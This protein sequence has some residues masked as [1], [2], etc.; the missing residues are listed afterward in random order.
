MWVRTWYAPAAHTPQHAGYD[1][2]SASPA[3][4]PVPPDGQR[5]SCAPSKIDCPSCSP[6]LL[7]ARVRNCMRLESGR[8]LDVGGGARTPCASYVPLPNL[9]TLSQR[10]PEGPA[11]RPN[12]PCS[13]LPSRSGSA[14][15]LQPCLLGN[16][17]E[18]SRR[19]IKDALG[20]STDSSK[21][22]VGFCPDPSRAMSDQSPS[23]WTPVLHAPAPFDSGSSRH[24]GPCREAQ[25][26]LARRS[27]PRH[28][29]RSFRSQGPRSGCL[30]SALS[31][32]SNPPQRV[33]VA[34][35]RGHPPEGF[36]QFFPE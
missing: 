13:F 15:S 30:P 27:L 33:H 21:H 1:R 5:L 29:S 16:S 31:L 12:S 17:V 6:R 3:A 18:G 10:I 34:H 36:L 25:R 7:Q 11:S 19:E 32:R 26:R 8:Y 22:V 20:A 24:D 2:G 28:S 35:G 4:L 14:S 9:S 23:A